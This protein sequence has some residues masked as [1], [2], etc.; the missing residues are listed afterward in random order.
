MNKIFAIIIEFYSLGQKLLLCKNMC[1]SVISAN[2]RGG[3]RKFARN[4]LNLK[5]VDKAPCLA[6]DRVNKLCLQIGLRKIEI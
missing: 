4:Q 6:Q 5:L 3:G 2:N 1:L